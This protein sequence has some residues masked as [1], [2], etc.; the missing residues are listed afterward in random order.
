M[1]L[2][3]GAS[4]NNGMH[5]VRHLLRTGAAVRALLRDPSK[6]PA[7]ARELL[8][9][10]VQVV[11][12][13]LGRPETLLPALAGVSSALLLSPVD[14][15]MVELQGNFIRAAQKSGV[16]YIVKFSMIGAAA[17]SPVPLSQ[18]HRAAE[19]LLEESGIRWTHI[20]PNDLMRY[21][22]RLLLPGIQ[23]DGVFSD[24]L[25][26]ARISMVDEDDVAAVAARLLISD[27]HHGK[28]YV[29]TGPEA[30]SFSD[31]A[32]HLSAALNQ[33]VRYV[34]ITPEQAE[35]A[36][37]AGGLPE[38]AVKLV[39]ALRAYER[40]NHNAVLTNTVEELL[41]R[42]PNTYRAVVEEIA[43]TPALVQ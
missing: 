11:T 18:W 3:T 7:K 32:K 5:I 8:N 36:M 27:G 40:E 22:T 35:A 31:I 12:G 17:D 42:K 14:P 37:R 21:N 23:K 30:L 4:G 33:P 26:D 41:G 43:A 25:G 6:E 16:P 29:L 39:S 1:T 2:V 13:D 34:S 10:G 20:R 38:P 28:T 19:L 24:S 15:N 9:S